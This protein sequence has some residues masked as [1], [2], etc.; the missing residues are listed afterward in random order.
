MNSNQDE[1]IDRLGMHLGITSIM[2]QQGT[3]LTLLKQQLITLRDVAKDVLD[4]EDLPSDL[5]VRV[6]QLFPDAIAEELSAG[7]ATPDSLA[8]MPDD[9]PDG[10]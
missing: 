5:L 3:A 9:D 4:I 10:P 6:V 2:L 1:R 7:I 8:D